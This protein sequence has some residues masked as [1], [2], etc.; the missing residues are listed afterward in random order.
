MTANVPRCMN[1]D[2]WRWLQ[3][4]DEYARRRHRER[5]LEYPYLTPRQLQHRRAKEWLLHTDELSN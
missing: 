3:E 1:D 2:A 4:H 5:Y